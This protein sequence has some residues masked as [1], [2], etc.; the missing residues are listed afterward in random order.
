M[1][2]LHAS[3]LHDPLRPELRVRLADT[4]E[5]SREGRARCGVGQIDKQIAW[6]RA[7]YVAGR[8]PPRHV[9]KVVSA[10][11]AYLVHHPRD[12]TSEVHK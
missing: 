11:E 9:D 5:G 1:G 7:E 3:E 6:I 4:L 8:L 2:A 12:V 10:A